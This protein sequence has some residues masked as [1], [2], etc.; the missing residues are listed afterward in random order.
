MK[1]ADNK[2]PQDV[3]INEDS[4]AEAVVICKRCESEIGRLQT[5]PTE[6]DA[7]MEQIY[8]EVRLIAAEHRQICPAG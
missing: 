5:Q 1:L 7:D 4:Q 2:I 8:A 6:P 3:L